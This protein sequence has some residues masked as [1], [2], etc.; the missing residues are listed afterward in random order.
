MFSPRSGGL[1]LARPFKGRDE[2]ATP[3][4]VALAT[5]EMSQYPNPARYV[6]F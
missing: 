5:A 1:N 6:L 3:S 2:A 4:V